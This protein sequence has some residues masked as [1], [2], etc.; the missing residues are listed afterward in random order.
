MT[1]QTSKRTDRNNSD[2]NVSLKLKLRL[3]CGL[4]SVEGKINK[5]GDRTKELSNEE[6]KRDRKCIS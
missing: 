2:K 3:R 1:R 4:K 6:R 5:L